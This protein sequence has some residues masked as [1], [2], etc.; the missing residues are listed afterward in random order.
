MKRALCTAVIS[1]G[2][3]NSSILNFHVNTFRYVLTQ[4]ALLACNL[5]CARRNFNSDAVRDRNGSFTYARH[6][7]LLPDITKDFAA[8]AVATSLSGSHQAFTGRK[9]GYAESA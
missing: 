8:H 3:S 2:D 9:N 1:S 4:L 6:L 5:D 7:Y